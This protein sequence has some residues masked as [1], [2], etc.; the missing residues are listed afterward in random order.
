MRLIFPCALF[1]S[2]FF[3]PY[4][5]SAGDDAIVTAKQVNGTWT[6]SYSSNAK[7]KKRYGLD[8]VLSILA[9]GH[10]KLKVQF[11]G[12]YSYADP[13]GT[14]TANTGFAEGI[15]AIDRNVAILKPED[16]DPECRITLTFKEAVVVVTQDGCD[17][18]FGLHVH[19]V[20]TYKKTSSSRPRF[21]SN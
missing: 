13:G 2:V 12:T 3:H 4:A 21:S 16:A 10:Q 11:D 17:G 9:L 15:A 18:L 6:N 20:G 5:I 1:I 8:Q 14:P 7:G 19:A